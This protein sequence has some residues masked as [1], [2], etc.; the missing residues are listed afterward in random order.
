[1]SVRIPEDRLTR[2][3]KGFAFVVMENEKAAKKALNYDGHKVMNKPL[4]V[5][6]ADPQ[7]DTPSRFKIETKEERLNKT[8]RKRSRSRSNSRKPRHSRRR[9]SSSSSSYNRRKLQQKSNLKYHRFDAKVYK[10]DRSRGKSQSSFE[11]SGF[12]DN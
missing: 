5:K 1:M 6:F 12:D 7:L 3:S 8:E 10:E 2:K 11:S 9:S 4:K